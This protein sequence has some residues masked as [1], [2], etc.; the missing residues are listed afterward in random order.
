MSDC[1]FLLRTCLSSITQRRSDEDEGAADPTALL[2]YLSIKY[3]T[4]P[5]GILRQPEE[6]CHLS[7]ATL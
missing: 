5:A 7:A 1:V 2:L 3:L 6:I 4:F